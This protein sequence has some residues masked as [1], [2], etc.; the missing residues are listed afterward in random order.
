MRKGTVLVIAEHFH[1]DGKPESEQSELGIYLS[2]TPPKK[3]LTP[4]VVMSR[5]IAIAPGD[6]T[7]TVTAESRLP[8]DLDLLQVTPHAHLICKE[9][10][11]EAITPDKRLSL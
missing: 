4:F 8:A 6:K 3:I 10:K 11:G 1:P 5:K 2:K 7:Y 9:I